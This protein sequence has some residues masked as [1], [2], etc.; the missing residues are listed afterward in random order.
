MNLGQAPA[1]LRSPVRV[2]LGRYLDRLRLAARSAGTRAVPT[3]RDRNGACRLLRSVSDLID[4][5]R[6]CHGRGIRP[7]AHGSLRYGRGPIAARA[8][9]SA[10]GILAASPTLAGRRCRASGHLARRGTG[11]KRPVIFKGRCRARP[12]RQRCGGTATYVAAGIRAIAT[13]WANAVLRVNHGLVTPGLTLLQREPERQ[14][15]GLWPGDWCL[16]ALSPLRARRRLKVRGG[17]S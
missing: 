10:G 7:W 6:L 9:C 1:A 17:V 14:R 13:A 4:Y 11:S 2:W 12:G 3:T 16:R 8:A 5:E 15:D